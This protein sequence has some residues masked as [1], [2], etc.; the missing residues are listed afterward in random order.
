MFL[1][2]WHVGWSA[3]NWPRPFHD[4]LYAGTQ[5][6]LPTRSPYVVHVVLPIAAQGVVVVNLWV[7]VPNLA[8]SS[9]CMALEEPA[10]LSVP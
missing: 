3:Q 9:G 1:A 7:S 6:S 5:P 10:S 4:A 2:G 8:L